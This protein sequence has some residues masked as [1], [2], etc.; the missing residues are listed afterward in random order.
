LRVIDNADVDIGSI[1]CV[2]IFISQTAP[3]P[4]LTL[5]AN[6][7]LSGTPT[8]AGTFNFTVRAT[9]ANQCTSTR[10]YTLT[11]GAGNLSQRI[12]EQK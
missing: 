8:T 12:V 10:A 1:Q 7:T 6:G 2:S 3:A 11:I 9:D 5:A 4:G